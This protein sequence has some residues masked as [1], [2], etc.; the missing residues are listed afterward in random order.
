MA[1]ASFLEETRALFPKQHRGKVWRWLT[2]TWHHLEVLT[3]AGWD[4]FQQPSALDQ[5]RPPLEWPSITLS[6]DQGGDGWSGAHF[7][8]SWNANVLLLFDPSHRVWND[9]T[10]AFRDN[11]LYYWVLIV[12]TVINIDHGPFN[13]A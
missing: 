9:C 12:I 11:G 13:S 4:R 6:I 8:M 5:R 10:L 2:T 1:V 3:G 7:L